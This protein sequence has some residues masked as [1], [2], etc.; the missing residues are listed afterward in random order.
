[1]LQPCDLFF[2]I[3]KILLDILFLIIISEYWSLK[4]LFGTLINW[5]M[6]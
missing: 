6:S 2:L 1:M 5:I 4:Y 3:H